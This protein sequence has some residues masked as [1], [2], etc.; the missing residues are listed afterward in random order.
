MVVSL[1]SAE[2]ETTIW[3]VSRSIPTLRLND[4]R[5]EILV[6]P[7]V[8][9]RIGGATP[10]PVTGKSWQLSFEIYNNDYIH[11]IVNF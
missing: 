4:E 9:R 11:T 8:V 10:R 7:G 2:Q 5:G 1:L 6:L 3:R